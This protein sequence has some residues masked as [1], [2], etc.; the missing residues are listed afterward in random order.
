MSESKYLINWLKHKGCQS[1]L[2]VCKIY[3][4][5]FARCIMEVNNVNLETRLAYTLQ[6]ILRQREEMQGAE[7]G[8]RKCSKELL[9][10]LVSASL[11]FHTLSTVLFGTEWRERTLIEIIPGMPWF[12]GLPGTIK[13]RHLSFIEH[14]IRSGSY[15]CTRFSPTLIESNSFLSL[16]SLISL[17]LSSFIYFLL[18]QY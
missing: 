6:Y 2:F 14:S 5:A 15:L 16:N 10:N 11:K 12:E 13:Y 18:I 9:W 4:I 7:V 1:L 3:L 8:N 17:P